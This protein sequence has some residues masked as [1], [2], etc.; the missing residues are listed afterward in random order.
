MAFHDERLP[1][2]LERG[3][4]GGPEF[5]TTV[6]ALASGDEKRN[7]DWEDPRGSWDVGYGL[8][9]KAVSMTDVYL[10]F[11]R[12]FFYARRGRVHSFRFKDWGDFEIGDLLAPTV[13]NQDLGLGDD[14]TT[15]FQTIKTYGDGAS[16]YDRPIY[17]LVLGTP[18]VLL[19]NVVQGSGF[20]VD[21]VLGTVTF[22]VPPASTGGSGPGGEQVV[23]IVSE[24]DN[25]VRFDTDKLDITMETFGVGS[26]PNIPITELRGAG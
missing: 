19:D 16:T 12:D 22:T 9:D 2:E 10:N 23:A 15:V 21:L 24:F 5:K 7:Q 14:A 25:H 17:K 11:L 3:A 13:T 1:E 8:I 6:F 20:S 18:V 4:S 26:W